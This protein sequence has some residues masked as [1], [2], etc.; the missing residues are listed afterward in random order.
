[1]VEAARGRYFTGHEWQ[2]IDAATARIIPTDHDPGAREAN[3]VGF[4]DRYLSGIDCIYANPWGSGFLR[5]AGKQADAWWGR[6]GELRSRYRE[7]IQRLDTLSGELFR[8][9][10]ADLDDA[11][12]DEVLAAIAPAGGRPHAVDLTEPYPGHADSGSAG[13]QSAPA[14]D[15]AAIAPGAISDSGLDFFS[16][17]VVHTRM[18]FYAD[19]V[20]GGNRN[21][22]G[23]Q[24]IGFPGPA[25]LA[26]TNDGRF[27]TIDHMTRPA[28]YFGGGYPGAAD[29]PENDRVTAETRRRQ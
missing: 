27:S 1:M 25:S 9:A 18:G 5:L 11:R 16:T 13:G 7:G 23:W 17:L 12:Q 14:Q 8:A 2:T 4:I 6:I 19:P 21:R 28:D 24:V 10:F 15:S 20:Y 29:F 22:V 26:E 3:V